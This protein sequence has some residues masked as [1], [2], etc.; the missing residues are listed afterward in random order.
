MRFSYKPG[1]LDVFDGGTGKM[2]GDCRGW[3]PEYA[4]G[5]C[6]WDAYSTDDIYFLEVC[7]TSFYCKN[8]AELFTLEIDDFFV[9]DFSEEKFDELALLFTEPPAG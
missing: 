2:L 9:C 1:D 5:A 6:G 4:K 3:V 8:G 7:M